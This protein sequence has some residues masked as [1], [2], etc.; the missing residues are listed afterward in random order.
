MYSLSGLE[1]SGR[2]WRS[3]MKLFRIVMQSKKPSSYLTKAEIQGLHTLRGNID[4]LVLSAD[5]GNATAILSATDYVRRSRTCWMIHRIGGWPRITHSAWSREPHCCSRSL[6][7]LMTS[8]NNCDYMARGNPRCT[9]CLKYI[10]QESNCGP[11]S[12]PLG[13]PP[14]DFINTLT[15]YCGH[16]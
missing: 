3:D 6:P 5:S 2:S 16:V 10:R 14:T 1:P 9:G 13:L 4:L 8:L 7:S 12:A 11:S 15:V